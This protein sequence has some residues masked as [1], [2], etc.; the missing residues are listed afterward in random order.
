[1][2]V[3]GLGLL[4]ELLVPGLSFAALAIFA[5]GVGFAAVWL[6][7]RIVGAT[8]PA[9]VF[10]AWGLAEIATDLGYLSGDG[11][12]SLFVGVAF[13]VGWALARYQRAHRTWAL[14]LGVVFALIGLAD[15]SDALALDLDMFVI[16]PLAMIAAGI[17]LIVRTRLPARA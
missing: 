12:T 17:F 15:V 2:V 9:L 4:L 16:I 5:I 11:W 8:V 1:M 10:V 6:L 3:L 13:L 14:V 7:G